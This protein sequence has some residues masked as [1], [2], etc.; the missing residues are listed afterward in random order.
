MNCANCDK[1][2]G[3]EDSLQ[4]IYRNSDGHVTVSTSDWYC[5]PC[6]KDIEEIPDW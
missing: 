5:V 6:V 2:I 3:D 4:K 1:V